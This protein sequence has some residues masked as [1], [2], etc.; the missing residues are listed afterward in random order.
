MI[1]KLQ[2]ENL[3]N[4]D[5]NIIN[6]YIVELIQIDKKKEYGNIIIS[7]YA[8]KTILRKMDAL[9]AKSDQEKKDE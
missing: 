1:F 2:N 5:V 7:K 9:D 3:L 6:P 4:I 8:L